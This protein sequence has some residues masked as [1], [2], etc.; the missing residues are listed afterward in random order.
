MEELE[1]ELAALLSGELKT[2]EETVTF[3]AKE[4]AQGEYLAYLA[5]LFLRLADNQRYGPLNTQLD[6]NFLMEE[7][8]HPSD[9][10]SVKRLMT[11]LFRQPAP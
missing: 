9:V 7:Q 4:G 11:D 6:T 1:K 3:S 5:Y 2:I 8:E 10:L